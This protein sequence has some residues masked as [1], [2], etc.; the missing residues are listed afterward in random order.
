MSL[1]LNHVNYRAFPVLPVL[2]T[3][4]VL[5]VIPTLVVLPVLTRFTIRL[6]FFFD[7]IQRPDELVEK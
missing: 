4:A 5:P 3:L 6:E 7:C 1:N 2:P